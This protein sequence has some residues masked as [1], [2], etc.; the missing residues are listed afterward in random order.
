M[1][2]ISFL[3]ILILISGCSTF[4]E[5]SFGYPDAYKSWTYNGKKPTNEKRAKFVKD[6]M[7]QCGF[8][9]T[10]DNTAMYFDNKGSYIEASLCM[11]ERGFKHLTYSEGICSHSNYANEPVCKSR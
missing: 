4:G 10:S 11:E 8:R 5:Y 7:L 2:H 6:N 3:I 1:R 9:N